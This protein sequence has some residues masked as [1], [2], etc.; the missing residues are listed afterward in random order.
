M[1]S[2]SQ[3]APQNIPSDLVGP[4]KAKP[5]AEHCRW[6]VQ[7]NIPR[8]DCLCNDFLYH[9]C[10][11]L[12]LHP[13][14]CSQQCPDML[15]ASRLQQVACTGAA[16][17][18]RVRHPCSTSQAVRQKARSSAEGWHHLAVAAALTARSILRLMLVPLNT[19]DVEIF[20]FIKRSGLVY[21]F[22]QVC[23]CRAASCLRA[24]SVH[25]WKPLTIPA[26][27]LGGGAWARGLPTKALQTVK[28]SARKRD[29]AIH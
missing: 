18:T 2:P 16:I 20:I 25:M 21:P 10:T 13:S 11:P 28:M 26:P 29:I 19:I 6:I 12:N 27:S 4:D 23:D 15:C 8:A 3:A 5:I 22:G 7:S 9:Q 1:T 24:R 14:R 17:S